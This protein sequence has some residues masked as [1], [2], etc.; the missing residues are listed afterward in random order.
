MTDEPWTDPWTEQRADGKPLDPD[1]PPVY[2]TT[3]KVIAV[4]SFCLAI[5]AVSIAFT[6]LFMMLTVVQWR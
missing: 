2:E 3:A 6:A 5:I 1:E 4:V